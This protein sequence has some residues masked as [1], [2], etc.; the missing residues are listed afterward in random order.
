MT[1]GKWKWERNTV[2][3]KCEWG[4]CRCKFNRNN[5]LE[6]K[7]REGKER[8]KIREEKESVDM[9]KAGKEERR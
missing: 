4:G 3:K 8:K 2:G 5:I 7:E 6:K 9:W 1:Y